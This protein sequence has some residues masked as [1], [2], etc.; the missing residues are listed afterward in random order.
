[1]TSTERFLKY[2]SFPTMSDENSETTPSTDKQW[3]LLTYLKDELTS[4]GLDDIC[5]DD[6]GYL[7]ATLKK[8]CDTNCI[9]LGLI[10]HVDTAEACADSP[11]KTKVVEYTG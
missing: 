1:M 2:V 6:K 9:K 10:A 11:I 8:N 4:L 5:L 3:A 7:Y